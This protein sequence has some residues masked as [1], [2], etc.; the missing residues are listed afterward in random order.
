MTGSVAPGCGK[1]HHT[2]K[3][4]EEQV[5]LVIHILELSVADTETMLLTMLL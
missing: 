3:M 4:L 5:Q 2:R 1:N